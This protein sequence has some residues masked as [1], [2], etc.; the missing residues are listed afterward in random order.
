MEQHAVPQHIAAF[1][2]KLFGNLT[3]RQFVSLAI[4]MAFAALVFFSGITPIIR[5]PVSLALSLLGLFTALVPI[6]GRPFD[7][8]VV[9]FIK[10]IMSPTQRMWIKEAKLPEFLNIVIAPARKEEKIPET[11]TAQGRQRLTEYLRSLPQEENSPLDKQEQIALANLGLTYETPQGTQSIQSPPVLISTQPQAIQDKYIGR[12]QESLPPTELGKTK[13]APRITPISRAYILPGLEKKF[14]REKE[15]I[16]LIKIPKTEPK[17]RLAS[18]L[19]FSIENIIPI[20]TPDHKITLIPG[21][22]KTRVRKLHA[23]PP[24]NTAPDLKIRGEN[25]FEIA[26]N[27]QTVQ[28]VVRPAPSPPL[29]PTPI[30]KP[31]LVIDAHPTVTQKPAPQKAASPLIDNKITVTRDDI[32]PSQPM[33]SLAQIIPLTNR[34]N[35]LSGVVSFANG[36]PIEGAILI[37]HDQ[38]GIPVRALKTNKLGQFLSATP[39]SEGQYSIEVESDLSEF[40]P[41]TINLKGEVLSPMEIKSKGGTN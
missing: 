14:Q 41:I 28:E 3:I 16:E 39:L 5:L 22:G 36:T 17:A 12:Y 33:T 4:P 35:V 30:V 38:N 25:Q 6:Q 29:P 10:A 26:Q 37:V 8:W 2:F 32:K 34:P 20:H 23:A 11:I 15:Y 21:I 9:A 31:K 13:A 40:I 1:E 27:L 18:N 24:P 7:K 19:N